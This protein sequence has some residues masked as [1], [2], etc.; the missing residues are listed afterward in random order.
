MALMILPVGLSLSFVVYVGSQIINGA[1]AVSLPLLIPVTYPS[2]LN[3][4]SSTGVLS[5]YVPPWIAHSLEN[6][7]GR[8]PSP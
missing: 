5:M 6:A 7:S 3:R 2:A 4:I 1:V 8:P